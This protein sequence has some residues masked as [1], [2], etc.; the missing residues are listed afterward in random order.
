MI[1]MTEA[2]YAAVKACIAV[3]SASLL[4]AAGEKELFQLQQAAKL[5]ETRLELD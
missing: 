1:I 2:E 5:W 4:D 3:L